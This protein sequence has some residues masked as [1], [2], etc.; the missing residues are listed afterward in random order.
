MLE[1]YLKMLIKFHEAEQGKAV[2]YMSLFFGAFF[3]LFVLP[4]IFFLIA[5]F[6]NRYISFD[7]VGVYKFPIVIVTFLIGLSLL[8]WTTICQIKIGQGTPAPNA[9]TQKLVTTGPYKYT[10]N[11]IELG[12]LFYYFSFGCFFG[13]TLHG[14]TC[15]LLG[16]IIGSSYHKFIEEK[17]LMLR[18]GDDYKKYKENTPFLIPKVKIL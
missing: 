17:E 7:Y 13:S 8:L 9:P 6:L 15:M 12:A 10:R 18:F 11:P 16:F 4:T 14:I 1:R 5:Q 3:F 2:Q